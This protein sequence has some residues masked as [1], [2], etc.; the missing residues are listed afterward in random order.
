M[1]SSLQPLVFFLCRMQL[2]QEYF[3]LTLP[4]TSDLTTFRL[5]GCNL[6]RAERDEGVRVEASLSKPKPGNFAAESSRDQ[7][8]STLE[9]G[10]GR[11]SHITH[12]GVI[13]EDETKIRQSCWAVFSHDT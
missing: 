2:E 7:F 12:W 1:K 3:S 5:L 10:R 8:N 9:L 4:L 6:Q 13:C 11:Y